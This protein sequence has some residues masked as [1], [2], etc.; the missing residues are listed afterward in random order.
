MIARYVIKRENNVT[1]SWKKK[2]INIPHHEESTLYRG[3]I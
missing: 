2:F 3:R 1:S